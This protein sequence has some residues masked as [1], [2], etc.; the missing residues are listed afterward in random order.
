[1]RSRSVRAKDVCA[2][3]RLVMVNPRNGREFSREI[4]EVHVNKYDVLIIYKDGSESEGYHFARL[5]KKPLH[6]VRVK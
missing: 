4:N 3:D 5:N 6:K 2:G 1:M